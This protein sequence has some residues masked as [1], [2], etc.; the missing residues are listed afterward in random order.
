MYLNATILMIFLIELQDTV[1]RF[2]TNM[3]Q[4][5]VD[6]VRV[7]WNSFAYYAFSKT[8]SQTHLESEVDKA[9]QEEVQKKVDA[10]AKYSENEEGDL[11]IGL[12]RLNAGRRIDFVLQEAPIESFNEYL[13]SL[14]SHVCYW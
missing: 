13:F 9:V 3:R 14:S 2:T 1:A 8:E 6:T 10:A 4:Q 11:D 5:V 12:G 7:A